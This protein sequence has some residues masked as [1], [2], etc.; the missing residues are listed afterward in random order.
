M[1]FGTKINFFYIKKD[2]KEIKNRSL[3]S[4]FQAVYYLLL[5]LV[6]YYYTF[7]GIHRFNP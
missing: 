6:D 5:L 3:K 1:F 7:Q 4:V 2:D